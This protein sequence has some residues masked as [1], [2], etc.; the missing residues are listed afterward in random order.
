MR[1]IILDFG[2]GNTCKNDESYIKKMYDSL[3]KIDSNKHKIIVKWQLFKHAGENIP[4]TH[5]MFKYA[6]AYG[7]KIGYEVTSSVFDEY[8]LDFLLTENK[9]LPFIK[10]AN[11]RKLDYL[12]DKIPGYIPVYVSI[13][14]LPNFKRKMSY[15]KLFFCISKYPATFEDYEQLG[16]NIGFNISD[17]TENFNLYHKYKPKIVEW[18]Y[19]LEDSTGLDSGSFARTP[20]QL[21]EIL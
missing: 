11:N 5:K 3:K 1:T 9:F 19:K 7:T 13:N 4:L 6:Y 2:S 8:S 18:H 12:V 20:K 21:E 16:F 14:G 17:H 10:I 15:D